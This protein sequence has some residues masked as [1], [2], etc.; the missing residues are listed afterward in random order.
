MLIDLG[1]S[2]ASTSLQIDRG[3]AATRAEGHR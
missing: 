1:C 2:F 3:S